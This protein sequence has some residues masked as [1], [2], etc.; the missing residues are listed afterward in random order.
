MNTPTL[1][2]RI[3]FSGMILLYWFFLF[4]LIDKILLNPRLKRSMRLL[5]VIFNAVVTL[6]AIHIPNSPVLSMLV[7]LVLMLAEFKLCYKDSAVS[8]LFCSLACILHVLAIRAAVW[9]MF[10]IVLRLPLYRIFD[11]D[12]SYLIAEIVAFGLLNLAI[13]AVLR[14]LP[15]ESVRIVINHKEHS[16]FMIAWMFVNTVYLFINAAAFNKAS[17][18]PSPTINQMITPISILMGLYII[19]IFAFKTSQLL[20]YKEKSAELEQTVAQEQQYRNSI[21]REALMFYEI[22]IT[23]NQALNGFEDL[24]DEQGDM[25]SSYTEILEFMSRK[26]VH[27]DDID[28]FIRYA[29]AENMTK[30]YG[31]GKSEISIEYRRILND[32]EYSW[33]RSIVNLVKDVE[34]GDLLAY[35]CI[36]NIDVEKRRQLE[37][38]Q[39]SERDPLTGLYNKE[40]TGQL[41]N[42]CLALG[43][44]DIGAAMFM[45]DVDS[46]KG[47]NDHLGHVYGDAVLCDLADRLRGIFRSDD[48]V[49]RIGGDEFIAY[50][51]TCPSVHKAKEKAEEILKAFRITYNSSS[52]E[53][54]SI[55]GS[56]G[57]AMFPND[58]DSFEL[59][60]NHA[61]IALYQAKLNGK[62]SQML[63]D[64][65]DFV[66]YTAKRTEI[67]SANSSIKRSFRNNRIEYVFKILYESD[68]SAA[69][70][71]SVL[72]LIASHFEF[73]RGYIFETDAGGETTSNTFE[74]C[75]AG[76][77]PQIGN[78][79]HISI[80]ALKRANESFYESGTFIFRGADKA[81]QLE[82]DILEPQGIKTMFQ[83]GIFDKSNLL[84]LIGFDNCISDALPSEADIDEIKTIC[85]ILSTFFVK[86]YVDKLSENELVLFQEIMNHLENYVYVVNMQTFEVLFMNEKTRGLMLSSG[87][88]APCY[89]F[90]RGHESQCEDCP[91]RQL[92]EEHL[93]VARLETFNNKLGIWTETTATPLRWRDGSMAAL[94]SCADVTKQKEEHLSHIA[95]LEKLAH[96]DELTGGRTYNKFC[97]DAQNILKERHEYDHLFVKLDIDNF[98]LLNHMYGYKKGDEV[99]CAVAEALRLSM[100]GYF[101]IY[102]RIVGDEFIALYELRDPSETQAL[103]ESF[104]QHFHSIIGED[105]S[106]KFNFPHGRY[107]V[108]RSSAEDVDLMDIFEKTNMAHKA[109]K[110]DRT[111][112]FVL[113]DES[114]T[115]DAIYKK[116]IENKM[117]AAL[118]NSEFQAYLQPKYRLQGETIG[119]AEALVRWEV[120]D[121]ELIFPDAFIPTFEQ[122]G[123]ITKLDL[124]MLR[125]V[126]VIIKGWMESGLESAVVSVNFSRLHL[127]NTHFVE[128]LCE[129]VDEV[130][131][132]HKYIEIEITE[133]VIYDNIETLEVLLNKLHSVGFTMSMDDFGSGYSSLSMLKDLP[134]D[135]I[136]MDR[137]FFAN[138]KDGER[139]KAVV[140][141]V[142]AMANGLGIRTVAEGVE[143]QEQ[144]NL[145]RELN[146]NMAQGYFFARPIP[147]S[148]FKKLLMTEQKQS[149]QKTVEAAL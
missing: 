66:G 128:D 131:I 17:I 111:K 7:M 113:Y 83:F 93:Q 43:A 34:T 144:I 23:K 39:K 51:R 129:I 61:D 73:E 106:F 20:G 2:L 11:D 138:P 90:L 14:F 64:G 148:D 1:T 63:Y 105:F 13:F 92:S 76:I 16:W 44:D 28:A 32:G 12:A 6:Y 75:A 19:L 15:L 42:E 31:Q 77:S 124:Y 146:C 62:N 8:A 37:L 134:V 35:M 114:I 45:V 127:G 65:G 94:V 71:H 110:R 120:P 30:E 79:Q 70:I 56:V 78:L 84:G 55:S 69:A 117:E 27:P 89:H 126:C 133:T 68:N 9:G 21:T 99:L 81:P 85:N 136:K 107:I 80:D 119:G 95:E 3:L 101:E 91:I 60:Y 140:G 115:N 74:W 123:F 132:P 58:G 25:T 47:V 5:P 98:K 18:Y 103:Y 137:S 109:A 40:L 142:I 82:R 108:R 102:A 22:N 122:N 49:G 97:E 59:L 112:A 87:N 135:V 24:H 96:V 48:I 36:R 46:F 141:S 145:L 10:S 72:E 125:K 29:S 4:I 149:K 130:G 26:M 100:R 116:E 53:K 50:M 139:S 54:Y 88:T 57:I 143:T 38:Q 118:K 104:L 86:Q 33:V 121:G 147:E 52:D 41:I 67:E